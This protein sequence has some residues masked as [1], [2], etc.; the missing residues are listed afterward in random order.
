[1]DPCNKNLLKRKWMKQSCLLV[2]TREHILIHQDTFI[3]YVQNI[4]LLIQYSRYTTFS[5]YYQDSLCIG[6]SSNTAM[7]SLHSRLCRHHVPLNQYTPQISVLIV[8]FT[9]FIISL[10]IRMPLHILI[11]FMCSHSW[12][13]D[14]R[15]NGI[16]NINANTSIGMFPCTVVFSNLA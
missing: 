6:F 9:C 5:W 4:Y 11:W 16:S 14:L 12:Q 3:L 2:R 7:H 15:H 10:H 13:C 8:S 1:M